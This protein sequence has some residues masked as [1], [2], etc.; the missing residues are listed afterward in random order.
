MKIVNRVLLFVAIVFATQYLFIA[1]VPKL[2]FAIAQYRKPQPVNTVIINGKTDATM[3]KVVL[4]NPDFI[5]SAV[6]YDVTDH[7][8]IISGEYAD[9]TMY[10][11]LAFY[12]NDVQP[13]QVRNNLQGFKT[14]Y[15]IRLSSVNR[16]NRTLRAKSKKGVI[17]M[18]VLATD[19]KQIVEAKRLQSLFTVKEVPQND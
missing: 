4:P 18:R 6:F 15:A 17:L 11:S 13:Y 10:S 8:L 3:R 12:G 19:P 1:A 9:S 2:I 14:K 7:D 16:V 5:Y